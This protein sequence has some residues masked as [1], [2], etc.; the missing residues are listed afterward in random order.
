MGVDIKVQS[1][2]HTYD[3]FGEQGG[4]GT[5]FSLSNSVFPL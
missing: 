1:R 4:T 3:I 2:I 5:C